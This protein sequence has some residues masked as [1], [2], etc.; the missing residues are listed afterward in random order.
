MEKNEV[1]KSYNSNEYDHLELP[2]R[3]RVDVSWNWPIAFG[4]AAELFVISEFRNSMGDLHWHVFSEYSEDIQQ[5]PYL[6]STLAG[7]A[8]QYCSGE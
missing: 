1:R 2:H 7:I 8:V 6:E 5:V 3:P 4:H